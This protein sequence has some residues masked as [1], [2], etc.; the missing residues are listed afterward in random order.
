VHTTTGC[1]GGVASNF[2]SL[3]EPLLA[4]FE[5]RSGYGPIDPM[6]TAP[7]PRPERSRRRPKSA[8]GSH[9]A[10]NPRCYGIAWRQAARSGRPMPSL[11]AQYPAAAL[12]SQSRQHRCGRGRCAFGRSASRAAI[13]NVEAETRAAMALNEAVDARVTASTVRED[14]RGNL[15]PP[16]YCL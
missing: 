14:G 4:R 8:S 9:A 2:T 5:P 6:Q 11:A 1:V 13:L 15:S 16:G 7:L 12:R 10:G 3:S